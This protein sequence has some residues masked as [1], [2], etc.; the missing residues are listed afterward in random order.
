MIEM[1]DLFAE[2]KVFQQGRAAVPYLERILVVADRDPLIGRQ[3]L[4]A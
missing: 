3:D 2:N 1:R 4:V